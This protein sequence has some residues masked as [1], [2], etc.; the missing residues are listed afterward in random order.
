MMESMIKQEGISFKELEQEIF[1]K[2]CELGREATV[3][4]LEAYDKHLKENR[5]QK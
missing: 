1:R 4:I 3:K 2:I 5:K